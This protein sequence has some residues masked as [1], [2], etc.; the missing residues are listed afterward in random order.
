[1]HH[2][3]H[4]LGERFV[5]GDQGVVPDTGGYVGTKVAVA[6]GVFDCPR[7]ELDGPG[8]VGPLSASTPV[9]RGPRRIQKAGRS[10]R[11]RRLDMVPW[12]GVPTLEPRDS[13]RRL[14]RSGNRQCGLMALLRG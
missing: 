14:L 3:P 13:A 5:T 4:R 10:Q 11:H 9:E 7:T 8:A 6:V 1:M 12:I 2:R